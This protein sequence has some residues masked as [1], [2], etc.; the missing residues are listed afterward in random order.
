LLLELGEDEKVNP[1]E[2]LGETFDKLETT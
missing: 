1:L 2:K